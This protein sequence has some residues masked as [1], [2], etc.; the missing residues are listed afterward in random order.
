MSAGARIPSPKS[1]ALKPMLWY[2]GITITPTSLTAFSNKDWVLE[3]QF[4]FAVAG[5]VSFF[6]AYWRLLIWHP[7]RLQSEDYMTR[8][9]GDD[10]R[11]QQA[12][13]GPPVAPEP[14]PLAPHPQGT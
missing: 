1:E 7:D 3:V 12:V 2:L 4:A 6:L 8:L 13:S 9:L 10:R 14:G 11:G 5:V